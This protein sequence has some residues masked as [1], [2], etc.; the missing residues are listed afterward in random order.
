M[1]RHRQNKTPGLLK[2]IFGRRHLKFFL[3]ALVSIVYFL[4]VV[5]CSHT[6]AYYRPDVEPL[7]GVS[8]NENDINQR[9]LLIGD[10]GAPEDPDPTLVLLRRWVEEVPEKTA[11]VFLGDNIY[12][13]GL[14]AEDHPWRSEA[15]RRLEAQIH[16]LQNTSARGVFI[17]GNH[18]WA[19]GAKEGLHNLNRQEKFVNSKLPGDE[20]FLPPDGCPGPVHLDLHGVRLIVLDTHWWFHPHKNPAACAQPGKDAVIDRLKKLTESAAGREVVIVGHHPLATHGPHGGFFSWKDHLFP[21]TNVKKWLWLPLPVIG[22]LYPL[23][24]W[25]VVRSSQDI[26]GSKYAEYI[27][28][29]TVAV[30]ESNP[31]I[32]A[33][34]H[35][36]S[37]QVIEMEK[38]VKYMLVSGAGSSG[39]ITEVGHGD[40]T[41]FAHSRAGF[42]AL[43]FLHD[44]RVLL[45]VI[46]PGNNVVFQKWVKDWSKNKLL[47]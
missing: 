24:R 39:K 15:Q 19:K 22:S 20:N 8:V 13:K 5:N 9:V 34:G 27:D 44:G 45:R 2:L 11:V 14:P 1:R 16:V 6:T 23:I 10:A 28:R 36:H 12:P 43:D 46:E 3:F 25:N 17:P 4:S 33:A 31:L 41:L 29:V 38:G 18:D 21:L 47:D 7:S 26:A 40:D 42:M 35:D 30:S 37:L 32:Y